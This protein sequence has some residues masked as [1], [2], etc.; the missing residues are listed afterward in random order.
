M[1]DSNKTD[2]IIL[3]GR[4]NPNN[5]RKNLICFERI[6]SIYADPV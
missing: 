2:N 6:I 1:A 5:P 4:S 3:E